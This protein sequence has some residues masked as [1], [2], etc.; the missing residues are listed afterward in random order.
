MGYSMIGEGNVGVFVARR[1]PGFSQKDVQHK[2]IPKVP[3]A[4]TIE[5]DARLQA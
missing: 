1:E 5:K 2:E 3:E 4:R